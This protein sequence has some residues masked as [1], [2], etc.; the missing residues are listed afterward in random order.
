MSDRLGPMCACATLPPPPELQEEALEAASSVGMIV[1]EA[2]REYL[3][4]PLPESLARVLAVH[5]V[6][7]LVFGW[8]DDAILP[9]LRKSE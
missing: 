6:Q 7:V 1:K 8:N 2:D 3:P 5:D 4:S 9:W